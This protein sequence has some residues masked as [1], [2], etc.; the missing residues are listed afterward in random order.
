MK[1]GKSMKAILPMVWIVILS[2]VGCGTEKQSELKIDRPPYEKKTY[3]SAE[4][5]QGDLTPQITLTLR[6]EGFETITYDAVNSDL[7]LEKVYV[8][9]GDHVE[10]GQLLVAFQSDELEKKMEE[11]ADKQKQEELLADHYTKLMQL[12]D[13]LDYSEDIASLSKDAEIMGLYKEEAEE[14]LKRYQITAKES[15]TITQMDS[16][17]QNGGFIPGKRLITEV[18]GSGN[19]E[20]DRPDEDV[21]VQGENYTVSV[22]GTEYQLRAERIEDQKILFTP[23]SDMSAISEEEKLTL[24]VDEPVLSNAVYV[25]EKAVHQT[26]SGNFVYRLDEDGYRTAVFVDTGQTVGSYTV[27]CNGLEAGEKVTL[28]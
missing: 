21:I 15:G 5:M 12:D 8:S 22:D 3:M 10:K 28:E 19:Y 11:A 7:K 27:I 20:A 26:D 14:K 18:S 16:N 1:K 23:V 24:V 9:V 25:D 2:L 13:T 6:A 17:L 4:V